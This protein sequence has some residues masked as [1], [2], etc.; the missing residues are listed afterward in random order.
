MP[1]SSGAD[2]PEYIYVNVEQYETVDPIYIYT[3]KE[4]ADAFKSK[5]DIVQEFECN[6]E[7]VKE[8]IDSLNL[9]Q[10]QR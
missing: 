3:L 8:F 2:I 7:L 5:K 9:D 1:S 10:T 6:D 4:Y